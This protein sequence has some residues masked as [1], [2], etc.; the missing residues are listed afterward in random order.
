ATYAGHS[1][2][3]TPVHDVN[4]QV[5]AYTTRRVVGKTARSLYCVRPGCRNPHH[6]EP[7]PGAGPISRLAGPCQTVSVVPLTACKRYGVSVGGAH[8]ER[9]LPS[10]L[11]LHH[12]APVWPRW[13]RLGVGRP[14][15]PR[16]PA[17]PR[18][19]P[20]WPAGSLGLAAVFAALSRGR[21][22]NAAYPVAA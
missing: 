4:A 8:R 21:G 12:A 22:R 16:H 2:S 1:T 10:G 19:G 17:G 7:P 3:R 15:H 5:T 20:A 11:P 13:A 18:P 14:D 6:R 9:A